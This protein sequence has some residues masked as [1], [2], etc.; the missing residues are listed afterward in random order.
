MYFILKFNFLLLKQNRHSNRLKW[1]LRYCSDMCSRPIYYLI[2][3]TCRS[4]SL[5][6]KYKFSLL[7]KKQI[8]Y[9]MG[10]LAISRFASAT[11][12]IYQTGMRWYMVLLDRNNFFV[13]ITKWHQP[14]MY[15]SNTWLVNR[16]MNMMDRIW[17]LG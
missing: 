16:T 6:G 9:T 10:L 4:F 2:Y 17:V 11:F 13:L 5:L 7:P 8:C 3:Y 14:N 12:F 1:D 15:I